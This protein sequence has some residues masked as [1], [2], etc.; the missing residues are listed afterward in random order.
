MS[1]DNIVKIL[2]LISLSLC[3]PLLIYTWIEAY[4]AN[5]RFKITGKALDNLQERIMEEFKDYYQPHDTFVYKP[6]SDLH[7]V[8]NEKKDE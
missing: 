8:E 7:I 1:L 2:C 3:I 5:K 6:K 4:K